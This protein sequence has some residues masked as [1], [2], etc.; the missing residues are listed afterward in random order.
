MNY[1]VVFQS[2]SPDILDEIRSAVLDNTPI[3]GFINGCG[4]DSYKLGQI[5]L[6]L[7]ETLP[8]ELL[9]TKLSGKTI[10]NIRQAFH[11]GID[12]YP[13]LRYYNSKELKLDADVIEVLSDF[14]LIGTV[15]DSVDFTVVPIGL[16]QLVCKGLYKGYPMWLIVGDGCAGMTK[17]VMTVLMRGLSLGV[18][19]HPFLSGDWGTD[20]MLL[21]FSYVKSVNINEFLSCVTSKFN[22]ACLEVLLDLSSKGVPIKKL[23]IQDEDGNPVY[24]SYQMF[25]L[26]DALQHNILSND[27]FDASL[28]DFEMNK[29]I[30]AILDKRNLKLSSLDITDD[31]PKKPKL[32]LEGLLD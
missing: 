18:D 30:Q 27:V 28:S 4:D 26:G 10:Y 1:G 20:A 29:K 31:E 12:V 14:V 21:L 25:A 5:R 11:K 16:V 6:A 7:R 19:I 15:I 8:V 17:E 2:C 32:K 22:V 24:N 3:S 13:L 23:C 9:S